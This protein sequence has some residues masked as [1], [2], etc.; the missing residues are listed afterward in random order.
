MA[1]KG[2]CSSFVDLFQFVEVMEGLGVV[3]FAGYGT[4]GTRLESLPQNPLLGAAVEALH[5]K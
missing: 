4:S 2:N 1:F 3:C 5:K